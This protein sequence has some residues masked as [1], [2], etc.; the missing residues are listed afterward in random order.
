MKNKK[1]IIDKILALKKLPM[2]I[3]TKLTI[4]KLQ[5]KLLSIQKNNKNGKS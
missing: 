5:Q 2:S 4:Q 1:E 3:K